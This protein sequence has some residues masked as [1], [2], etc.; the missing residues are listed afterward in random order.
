[1][2]FDI[3]FLK[4]KMDQKC[5]IKFYLE[6]IRKERDEY[7]EEMNINTLTEKGFVYDGTFLFELE[8]HGIVV[9]DNEFCNI[10]ANGL[11]DQPTIDFF[12]RHNDDVNRTF[13]IQFL[14]Q[15]DQPKY[16]MHFDENGGYFLT[17]HPQEEINYTFLGFLK[18][19]IDPYN[20]DSRNEKMFDDSKKAKYLDR[21]HRYASIV[22]YCEEKGMKF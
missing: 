1:M 20:E 14:D 19:Q 8:K 11:I 18:D 12:I 16:D 9:G 10:I 5:A 4:I 6:G 17:V 2:N 3:L 21:L 13:P 15:P 22:K 7:E